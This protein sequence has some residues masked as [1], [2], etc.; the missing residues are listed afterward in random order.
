MYNIWESTFNITNGIN[1]KIFFCVWKCPC[2]D[3]R[4]QFW[5]QNSIG[6]YN[7]NLYFYFNDFANIFNEKIT[8]LFINKIIEIN[9]EKMEEKVNMTKIFSEKIKNKKFK[10]SFYSNAEQ[11][12]RDKIAKEIFIFGEEQ[13][14]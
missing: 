12:E 11:E 6:S 5:T 9:K 8:K 2:P 14:K 7:N 3:G 4:R 10:L 1:W 13:N